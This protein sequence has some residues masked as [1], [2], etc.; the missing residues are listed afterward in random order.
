MARTVAE[1]QQ[2]L[3][4][5]GF[6]PGLI[7]GAAGENTAA[8]VVAFQKSRGLKETGK[9]DP[10][11][12]AELFPA[13]QPRTIQATLMDY[14]LNYAQSKIVLIAGALV[15]S[16]V[17]WVN[18]QFGLSVPAEVSDWVTTGLVLAGGGAIAIIRGW[19]KDT[20]RVASVTPAVI[21]KPQEYT[22]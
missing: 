14:V 15:V 5:R 12:L 16:V 4:N 19:G 7:D 10:E 13:A 17:G 21:Q 9:L 8:A 6:D 20:P 3:K 18:T 1:A 11:T 2:A 22:K